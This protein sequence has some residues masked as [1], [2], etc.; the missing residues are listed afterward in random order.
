MRGMWRVTFELNGSL[1]HVVKARNETAGPWPHAAIGQVERTAKHSLQ[2]LHIELEPQ[3]CDTPAIS[4]QVFKLVQTIEV[5]DWDAGNGFRLSQSKVD[6]N[7]SLAFWCQLLA[8]PEC[9]A[10]TCRAEVKLDTAASNVRLG[11]PGDFD[12]LTLEIVD[13]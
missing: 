7:S 4:W 12:A 13:P 1:R 11:G 5:I 3:V 10:A 2:V 9:D 8:T 6:R